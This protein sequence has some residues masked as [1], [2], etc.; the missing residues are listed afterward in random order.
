M[1]GRAVKGGGHGPWLRLLAVLAGGGW[2]GCGGALSEAAFYD[3]TELRDERYQAG[4]TPNGP[5]WLRR[6][7]EVRI[8]TARTPD[9]GRANLR[10][11]GA[12][13]RF[14][15]V[16]EA[17]A[18]VTLTTPPGARLVGVRARVLESGSERATAPREVTSTPNAG[19]VDPN[20]LRWTLAFADIAGSEILEYTA[21]FEVSGTLVTDARWLGAPDGTTR[22]V[23][24]RY[25]V[26][27]NA[28][29]ALSVSDP[30]I[31]A[32]VRREGGF[33]I[34][35]VLARFLGPAGPD[36]PQ[37]ASIRYVTKRA[38]PSGYDQSFAGSWAEVAAPYVEALVD[39]SPALREHH[40]PPFS[41]GATGEIG[42][43]EAYR[44]VRDR[45]QSADALRTDWRSAQPL[46]TALRTGP[47]SGTDK[48]HVLHWLLEAAGI[49]HRL[50]VARTT[51][52][53]ALS[54]DLPAP[55]VFEHA[56]IYFPAA[57][58]WLDP[59][60]QDCEPGAVRPSLAGGQALLLPA[61]G[62]VPRALPAAA[63]APESLAPP[64]PFQ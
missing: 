59:A 38:A 50:A 61:D 42:M 22:E 48:V 33:T 31:R 4:A 3:A 32:L 41:P 57:D 18:E 26:P 17:R 63:P 49:P 29:G 43:R 16:D 54:P 13:L 40:A 24:V 37:R 15:G 19:T 28:V 56:L 52:R 39:G 35:A 58:L 47:L 7:V 14:D 10:F 5:V 25:D 51:A 55:G 20:D 64:A 60:C 2:L 53:P 1:L 30:A 6:A 36:H 34:L 62:E 23:L 46:P 11:H 27:D 45:I 8:G 21:E 44:W 9:N 12:R